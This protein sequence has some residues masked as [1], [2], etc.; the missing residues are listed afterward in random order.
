MKKKFQIVLAA[1][2]AAMLVP[3]LAFS[4]VTEAVG[5]GATPEKSSV[6]DGDT[7]ENWTVDAANVD[8]MNLGRIWTDKTVKK[9]EGNSDFLT[10]LSAISSASNTSTTVTKPLDIVMVLDVSG[11]MDD[12][13]GGG[14][15]EKKLAALKT[16]ASSFLDTIASENAKVTDTE[17]K[18]KVS[19]VKFAGTSSDNVGNN[20][21]RGFFG[22]TYNYSQIVNN[23]TLCEG[24]GKDTLAS[25]INGLI[26][27]GATRADKGLEHAQR[28]LADSSA[29]EDAKKIVVFFTDG[30]PTS[31]SSF[32]NAVAS[33]AISKAKELKD[34]EVEVF[35]IGIFSD[36]NPSAD[37][38]AS[39]T[40]N[41]NKF[42]HAVSSNYPAAQ[43][44]Q[45]GSRYVWNLGT[46]ADQS[47]YYMAAADSDSLKKVFENIA[48]TISEGSGYPT[49][50]DE[51]YD[52]DKGG[53]VT[54]DDELGSYM[55]VDGFTSIN[56]GGTT[57]TN[58]TKS[59]SGNVDTYVF[60][61]S[62]ET[63]IY[64]KGNLNMV[65]I[66]VTR[67]ND[68]AQ[69]DKVQV[70]VPASLIPVRYF[71]VNTTTS[72]MSVTDAHPIQVTFAS[73]LKD[74]VLDSLAKPD[75]TLASYMA[76]N[77][78]T[79]GNVEFFANAWSGDQFLGDTT[80]TFFPAKG[81]TYYY[82]TEDTPIYSDAE[83]TTRAQGKLESD[84]DYYYKRTYFEMVD[85]KKVDR[86]R[87]VDFPGSVA[88]ALAGAVAQDASGNSYF[89]K[90]TARH[91][92]LDELYT[93]KT[94]N[95][96]ETAGDVLNPGWKE[97]SVAA[98]STVV[99][100]LGN[101]GKLKV[102]KPG[103][104][105]VSK[106]V[107]VQDGYSLDDYADKSFTFEISIPDVATAQGQTFP[108]EVKNAS[109]DTVG[110]AFG[111]AFDATGKA[112]HTLKHGETLYVYGLPNNAAY[113]VTEQ[114]AA[115]FDTTSEG[116]TGTIAAGETVAAAFTNTYSAE[117]TLDGKI[118]L[119]GSKVL[120]GRD[121]NE[122]DAF[123]FTLVG[124]NPED[125]P[126]PQSSTVKLENLD[127]TQSGTGVAFNFGDITFVKPGTYVYSIYE[128]KDASTLNK[129]VSYSKAVYQVTVTVTDAGDGTLNIQS[130]MQQRRDDAGDSLSD[131]QPAQVALFNNVFRADEENWS[132]RG[133]KHYVDTTGGSKPITEDM[134]YFRMTPVD[135]AP[136]SESIKTTDGIS[137]ITFDAAQFTQDNIGKTY[138]YKV[139]E[140]INVDGVWKNVS[141]LAPAGEDYVKDGMTYDASEWTVTVKV[142]LDEDVIVLEPTY[143]KNGQAT[144]ED[145]FEFLNHYASD[146][147]EYDTAQAGFNKVITGRDWDESCIFK[148]DFDK[149]SFDGYTDEESLSK[150]P[151]VKGDNP[152]TVTSTT[153]K[154]NEPVAF[155]FGKLNFT[156]TGTYVY[157][158]TEQTATAG[159]EFEYDDHEAFLTVKVTD[160]GLG[161]LVAEATVTDG[162]FT[163]DYVKD[164]N[165]SAAGDFNV[166]KVLT[167]RNMTQGQF[168]FVFTPDSASKDKFW[169]TSNSIPVS[170][171][172]DGTTATMTSTLKQLRGDQDL[173]FTRAD[174][175]KTY[176]FTVYELPTSLAGYVCDTTEWNVSIAISVDS[177]KVVATTTVEGK[178]ETSSWTYTA[179]EEAE[180]SAFVSFA[181]SYSA[182]GSVSIEADK[183]L[184]GRQINQDEF[185]FSLCYADDKR[186]LDKT[187]TNDEH[188]SVFFGSLNYDVDLLNKL[189]NDQ[190]ATVEVDNNGNKTWT[191]QYSAKEI[192]DNLP[193]GVTSEK[194]RFRLS[195]L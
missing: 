120:S 106:T 92:Y 184:T 69:G 57:F 97:S 45:S 113:T 195:S 130:T 154:E 24:T 122:T 121:W 131:Q 64:P 74:G 8:T 96:T 180:T 185:E 109:G 182:K 167:G 93:A 38:T 80:S 157:K 133:V 118:A 108:A 175:G 51:G 31:G 50:V 75:A 41:T 83:C 194:T 183:E 128:D 26:A 136:G 12:S 60:N 190:R 107:T 115:G 58:P 179:G 138:T 61:G 16:A 123:V 127:G 143:S 100:H 177:G 62:V 43:Y 67:S 49:E 163:N 173:V 46:R 53:Y 3:A 28:A 82:I 188:G 114:A 103:T 76:A 112:T 148:F 63:P 35:S 2:F 23:L 152:V 158:V 17:K 149:V 32:E 102:I 104:L 44:S 54:F 4:N 119:A 165:Y 6:V 164:L 189:V 134:F 140:V 36:A 1:V 161:N 174:T 11:S 187:F 101:N 105:T 155:D 39:G 178:G 116:D 170:A 33:S 27:G 15:S 142:T 9:G 95:V 20:T 89:V 37:P 125:A 25:S 111:L 151:D 192:T 88:E 81:N 193:A 56:F 139:N 137:P 132:P 160:N 135:G 141:E 171:A 85:G 79:E 191:I 99:N 166:E 10:T 13:F 18:H 65:V 66:A 144:T 94:T 40:S 5:A 156:E 181:N 70:K 90:G 86:V 42:M 98:A 30:Q 150:M 21:Y 72:E 117:G 91:T 34:A 153:A 169:F 172:D 14:S 126:L 52:P 159:T 77:S 168:K 59:T 78:D 71:N 19:I 162:T 55:K 145:K 7:T 186:V 47:E 110:D 147:V 87:V 146:P 22:N 84:K 124:A 68:L 29:R 176:K 48:S 73:S 129:G